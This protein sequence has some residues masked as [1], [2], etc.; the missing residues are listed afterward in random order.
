MSDRANAFQ[1]TIVLTKWI[2]ALES[3]AYKQGYDKYYNPETDAYCAMGVYFKVCQT[4][5]PYPYYYSP[6]HM[7]I[8]Q[9]PLSSS[10][11][12]ALH[13]QIVNMNDGRRMSFNEIADYL[14][15]RFNIPR[16]E[17]RLEPLQQQRLEQRVE[18]LLTLRPEARFELQVV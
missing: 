14:R 11:A 6:H 9:L 3:G 7:M 12:A 8:D 2:E 5:S 13:G 1:T 4:D 17:Q 18:Q 10:Y 15:Q 16:L